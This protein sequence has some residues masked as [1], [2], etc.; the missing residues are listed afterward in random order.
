MTGQAV[1]AKPYHVEA[2]GLAPALALQFPLL[3]RPEVRQQLE[4]GG[5]LFEFHLPVDHH[6]GGDH[7]E[8]RTPELGSSTRSLHGSTGAFSSLRRLLQTLGIPYCRKVDEAVSARY[9]VDVIKR[10]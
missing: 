1:N 3:R 6:G 5:P 8:V 7:D 2:V 4:G 10:A 9:S